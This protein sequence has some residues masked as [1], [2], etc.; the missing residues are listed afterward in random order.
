MKKLIDSKS[1]YLKSIAFTLTILSILNSCSKPMD[2]MYSM[3]NTTGSSTGAKGVS[4][5]PG[6]NEVWIQGMAFTPATITVVAGT[7]VT[8]TNK[9]AVAHTVTSDVGLFDSGT[10]SNAG[11]YSYI[12]ATTGTFAYHCA[13]HPSMIAKVVVN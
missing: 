2:N 13:F 9:D 6:S 5:G 7:T 8:W 3:G 4:A 12:F 10:F 11:T 1:M